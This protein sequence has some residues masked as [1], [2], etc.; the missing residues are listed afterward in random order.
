M[1]L[2]FR[3]CAAKQAV[4]DPGA[5]VGMS[6]P[7]LNSCAALSQLTQALDEEFLPAVGSCAPGHARFYLPSQSCAD[8]WP[9]RVDSRARRWIPHRGSQGK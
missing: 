2:G 4:T 8:L 5:A 3:H 1:S 9:V 6:A 7:R